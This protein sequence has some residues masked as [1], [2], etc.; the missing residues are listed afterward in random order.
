[1]KLLS[2]IQLILFIVLAVDF[3]Y[4]VPYYWDFA[5]YMQATASAPCPRACVARSFVMRPCKER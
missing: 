1:M 4:S 3:T 5:N 2:I